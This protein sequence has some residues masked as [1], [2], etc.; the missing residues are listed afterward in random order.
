MADSHALLSRLRALVRA[1]ME[2]ADDLRI[3]LE[4]ARAQMG[5]EPSDSD[6][7]AMGGYLHH[8]YTACEAALERVV[9]EVDGSTPSGP[10]S[11]RELLEWARVA[12]PSVRPRLIS[13]ST[14]DAL[15]RLLSFRHAYRHGYA[16]RLEWSRLGPLVNEAS[17]LCRAVRSDLDT[18]F[19][20]VSGGAQT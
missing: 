10:H 11:H 20:S 15:A 4:E 2:S 8:L 14:F 5:S 1:D 6:R 18:F 16:M 7:M 17:D 3:R 9:R 13:Q 19:E 12:V